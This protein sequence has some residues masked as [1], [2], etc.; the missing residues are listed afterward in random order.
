MQDF[1]SLTVCLCGTQV[2][3]DCGYSVESHF[4]DAYQRCIERDVGQLG[5]PVDNSLQ[6][7]LPIVVSESS[8]KNYSTKL[9]RNLD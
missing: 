3:I 8:Q 9:V 6:V 4:V 2:E 1:P 5:N 7:T